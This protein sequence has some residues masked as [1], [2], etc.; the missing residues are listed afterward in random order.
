MYR[1]T[2]MG[3]YGRVYTSIDAML[4]DWLNGKDFKILNGP[5]CSIRDIHHMI[6]IYD[7]VE[8]MTHD[9]ATRTVAKGTDYLAA[10][11]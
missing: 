7:A 8:L 11:I 2:L 9:G 4:H 5:Y 6:Q 3:A 10:I 1:L